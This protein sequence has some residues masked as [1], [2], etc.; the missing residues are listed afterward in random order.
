MSKV[1]NASQYL[2]AFDI[3][4]LPSVKEGFPYAILEAMQAGLPIVATKVGG[5]PEM[6]E[7]Q[8]NGILVQSADSDALAQAIIALLKNKSL[9][10]KFG[11]QAK[12]DF[13]NSFSLEKMIK[14]TENVYQN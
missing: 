1:L 10:E 9:A 8:S 5:I 3:Y 11:C 7:D 6:I 2:H 12:N 14:Q 4:T 13:E